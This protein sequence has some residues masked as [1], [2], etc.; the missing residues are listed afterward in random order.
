MTH[1]K[2]AGVRGLAALVAVAAL[3]LTAS[4]SAAA[5]G[6]FSFTQKG[7]SGDAFWETCTTSRGVTTCV[8]TYLFAFQGTERSTDADAFKGTRVCAEVDTYSFR[9]GG[10]RG[11]FKYESGCTTAPNGTFAAASD[12]SS[13]S[14]QPA[15]VTLDTYDCGEYDCTIVSSRDVAVAAEWSGYGS[16]VQSSGRFKFNDGTC[17]E[18]DSFKSQ[19]READAVGTLDGSSL[20]SGYGFISSGSFTF[21]ITCS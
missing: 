2:G 5:P 20:G 4:A 17:T 19:G 8:D 21:K 9:A 13:A 3:A 18:T 6:T 15:T 7:V 16:L 12:L 1:A 11:S 10:R 14:L